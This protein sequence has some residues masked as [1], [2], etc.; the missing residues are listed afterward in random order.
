MYQ[1]ALAAIDS[2]YVEQVDGAQ[3]VYGSIDGLLRTLDP[4]SSFLDP[5]GVRAPAR[6]DGRPLSGIGISIVSVDGL[7]TVTQLFEGSPAY[8]AGIR[9]NDVI[10][11]VG[12]PVDEG[13]QA[14]DRLGRDQGLADRGRRQA[15]ARPEGH[16]G[17]DLHPAPGRR[18]AHRSDRG[19]RQDQDH[20][21]CARRS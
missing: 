1:V 21:A 5:E 8:R 6:A 15:R 4:H 18:H 2:E 17:G 9:R 16:D 13:R 10:A 3:L 12:Q 11:R 20:D 14:A 19:A 7:I